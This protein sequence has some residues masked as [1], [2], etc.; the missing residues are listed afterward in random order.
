VFLF[1]TLNWTYVALYTHTLSFAHASYDSVVLDIA[2]RCVFILS[3][4]SVKWLTRLSSFLVISYGIWYL[5]YVFKNKV[6]F[7]WSLSKT[8]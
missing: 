6:I 4:N 1:C 8:E 2:L 7:L 5:I 3:Q